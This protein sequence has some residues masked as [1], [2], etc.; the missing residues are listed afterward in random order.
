LLVDAIAGMAA[1]ETVKIG[2]LIIAGG[3]N[4]A[5]KVLV[6]NATGFDL[7]RSVR[8]FRSGAALP[9]QASAHDRA[10][11]GRGFE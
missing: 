6:A 7:R 9:G 11:S 2:F 5:Q 4:N 1:V 10:V 8:G 3:I